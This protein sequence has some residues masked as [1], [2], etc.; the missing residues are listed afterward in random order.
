MFSKLIQKLTLIKP[1]FKNRKKFIFERLSQDNF[2]KNLLGFTFRNSKWFSYF[3]TNI[4]K[5]PIQNVKKALSAILLFIFIFL[6]VVTLVEST[7]YSLVINYLIQIKSLIA[8]LLT[9]LRVLPVSVFDIIT[10]SKDRV[11]NYWLLYSQKYSL[12]TFAPHVRESIKSLRS[13]YNDLFSSNKTS[14]VANTDTLDEEISRS[15]EV[16]LLL[17]RFYQLKASLGKLD[18]SDSV[19]SLKILTKRESPGS[20]LVHAANADLK[21]VEMMLNVRRLELNMYNDMKYKWEL[22]SITDVM[23]DPG[24][25]PIQMCKEAGL[26]KAII[27]ILTSSEYEEINPASDTPEANTVNTVIEDSTNITKTQRVLSKNT[28]LHNQSIKTM[29]WVTSTK[30][31]VTDFAN[32][33]DA[34]RNNIWIANNLTTNSTMV[35]FVQNIKNIYG[36]YNTLDKKQNER[37]LLRNHSHNNLSSNIDFI[38]HYEESFFW[39][40][41]QMSYL[42]SLD[43]ELSKLSVRLNKI[44]DEL[45]VNIL[46]LVYVLSKL[47]NVH[48]FLK[49]ES[50]LND[51]NDEFKELARDTFYQSTNKELFTKEMLVSMS[52]IINGKSSADSKPYFF[53]LSTYD[54]L[55]DTESFPEVQDFAT[56]WEET[57]KFIKEQPSPCPHVY[58]IIE[59]EYVKDCYRLFVLIAKLVEFNNKS[60][61]N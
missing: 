61:K 54:S 24:Y 27:S 4:N 13:Y 2:S 22:R 31:L 60:K 30:K 16:L 56:D 14:V 34:T 40:V 20:F 18:H 25:L 32:S 41:R 48:T 46:E 11:V 49:D 10:S 55:Y 15:V 21:V 51:I 37:E 36:D 33:F 50:L 43:S 52:E 8:V 58:D 26:D 3:K 47:S 42:G 39:I 44:V 59:R 28:I 17:K 1:F 5:L 38:K 45:D 53:K 12:K 57:R 9:T 35:N 29:N 19:R 23:L 6:L 7:M